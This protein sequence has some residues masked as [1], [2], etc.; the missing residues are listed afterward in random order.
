MP[1]TFFFKSFKNKTV[2]MGGG[3]GEKGCKCCL[4]STE[5]PGQESV[6]STGEAGLQAVELSEHR[7]I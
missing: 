1:V 6:R 2:M 4:P 3:R 7:N 5:G